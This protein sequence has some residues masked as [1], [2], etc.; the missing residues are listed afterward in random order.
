M[1]SIIHDI[2]STIIIII[3]LFVGLIGF[4]IFNWRAV[5]LMLSIVLMQEEGLHKGKAK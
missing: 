2:I 4:I 3:K 5:L 1:T